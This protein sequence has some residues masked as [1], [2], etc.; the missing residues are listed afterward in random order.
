MGLSNVQ[1]HFDTGQLVRLIP[2]TLI[3]TWRAYQSVRRPTFTSILVTIAMFATAANVVIEALI[4]ALGRQ[5]G[6]HPF[7]W[8][9]VQVAMLMIVW[10]CICIYYAHAEASRAAWRVVVGVVALSLVDLGILIVVANSVPAGAVFF[11]FRRLDVVRY[12]V[13][14]Q[15]AFFPFACLAA[16]WLAARAARV[17]TGPLK[18]AMYL[19][20]VSQAILCVSSPLRVVTIWLMHEGTS[21]RSR[22]VHLI[23]DLSGV[24]FY[25]GAVLFV[26]SFGAV[27]FAHRTKQLAGIRQA[28]RDNR[29]LRPLLATLEAISPANLTYPSTGRTPL[30]LRPHA[31]LTTT[32]IEIRDRLLTMS[33]WLGELLP[34]DD[35]DNPTEIAKILADLRDT[36]IGLV[37]ADDEPR[38]P[39][40]LLVTDRDDLDT[41]L[42]LADELHAC[43]RQ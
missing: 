30:L 5:R 2:V 20:S 37:D 11:D 16:C 28:V 23:L 24:C 18:F 21:P 31:R 35:H 41:L 36:G 8:G 17:A 12:H 38:L 7:M 14:I 4:V 40:R 10:C 33:P 3:G 39:V 42:G 32:S 25:G 1:I 27:A 34:D 15:L 29:R 26:L 13:L 9:P 6:A 22:R 19:A 43:T